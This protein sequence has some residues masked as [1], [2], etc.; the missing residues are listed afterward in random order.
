MPFKT[1][2]TKD[3]PTATKI[4][5]IRSGIRA[6]VVNDMVQYFHVSKSDIFEVL[7]TPESSAHK[8]IKGNR[9]LDAA[10]SERVVRIADITRTAEETFG[11]RDAAR[12]WLKTPNL[13]LEGAA[14]FSMLDTEPGAIEVRRI[15]SAINY[16]GVF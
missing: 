4:A 1:F 6:G 3:S 10:A 15:L 12:Q 9:P 7:R 16:G 2:V 11:E 5:M 13:A 14:P 8:L